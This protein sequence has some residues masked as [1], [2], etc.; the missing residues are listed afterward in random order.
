MKAAK[1]TH[2][3]ISQ[4]RRSRVIRSQPQIGGQGIPRFAG[5]PSLESRYI[6]RGGTGKGLESLLR[7]KRILGRIYT[8]HSCSQCCISGGFV[9]DLCKVRRYSSPT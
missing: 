6:H 7:K 8:Y 5:G 3:R 2:V 9:E 4:L 1:D